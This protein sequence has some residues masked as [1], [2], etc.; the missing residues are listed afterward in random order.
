MR[1]INRKWQIN[2]KLLNVQ[3]MHFFRGILQQ[4]RLILKNEI[5]FN[6][7]SLAV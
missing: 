1:K 5:L 2:Q 4:G 3:K 6:F 7:H